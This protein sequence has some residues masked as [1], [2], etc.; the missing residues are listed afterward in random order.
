MDCSLPSCENE[1]VGYRI[2]GG[3]ASCGHACAMIIDANRQAVARAKNQGR[4]WA[5]C[6][7]DGCDRKLVVKG[8]T[9]KCSICNRG[10]AHQ[11]EQD[12]GPGPII[13]DHRTTICRRDNIQCGG[14]SKC[15]DSVMKHKEG[16][17]LYQTNGGVNCWFA[18]ECTIKASYGSMLAGSIHDS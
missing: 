4:D 17:F 2:T 5:W 16:L 9:T 7:V 12:V 3:S 10:Q 6:S 1:V 13:I 14:F 15:S 18:P 11:E 8:K